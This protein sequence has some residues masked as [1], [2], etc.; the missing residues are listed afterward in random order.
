[1]R[2]KIAICSLVIALVVAAMASAHVNGFFN[3]IIADSYIN[4][5]SYQV[6]GTAL[7]STHLSDSFSL[8]RLPLTSTA[9]SDSSSLA[10]LN[11]PAFTGIPT[12]PTAA[13][14]TNTTQLATTAFVQAAVSSP[15]VDQ[16]VTDYATCTPG[17]STDSQCSGTITFPGFA[18]A[19]YSVFTQVRNSSGAFLYMGITSKNSSSFNYFVTCSYNCSTVSQP[20]ADVHLHHS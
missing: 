3:H 4:A 9:L 11:S 16:Y 1:M 12:A 6:S 7:A 13:S 2:N 5:A 19:N 15:V 10:R 14:G 18:D 20:Y 17:T 8:A